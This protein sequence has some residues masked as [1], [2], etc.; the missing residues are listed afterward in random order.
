M[1]AEVATTSGLGAPAAPTLKA[2][3]AAALGLQLPKEPLPAHIP[4]IVRVRDC[5]TSGPGVVPN[6][7]RNFFSANFLSLTRFATITTK[8]IVYCKLIYAAAFVL[9]LDAGGAEAHSQGPRRLGHQ[10]LLL[11]RLILASVGQR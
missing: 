9:T 1:S 2:S 6:F 3:R 5:E 4:K 8:Q 7:A 10:P 11:T